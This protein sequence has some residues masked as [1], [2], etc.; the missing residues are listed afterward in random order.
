MSEFE[1]IRQMQQQGKLDQSQARLLEAALNES[2]H[3]KSGRK[4]PGSTGQALPS[5][6]KIWL[7]VGGAFLVLLLA[8]AGSVNYKPLFFLLL[9]IIFSFGCS[10]AI[11]LVLFNV[12]VWKKEAVR[13]V[14]ALILNEL[15]RKTVLVP[16][17]WEAVGSYAKTEAETL[18]TVTRSR[19]P[20]DGSQP[21]AAS[22]IDQQI[23]HIKAVAESYPDIKSNQT[24][25]RLFDELVETEN[26]I[27]AMAAWLNH[28][29]QNY[30]GT[31][32]TFPFSLVASAFDFQKAN[33]FES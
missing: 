21:E 10:A 27:T 29:V 32:E 11:F 12:L 13:R 19:N 26:R 22:S 7:W 1:Q 28:K 16:Q 31:V 14:Q 9:L 15:D 30:N 17:I 23:S 6:K 3:R 25:N 20:A 33:Y 24:Y 8:L 2:K 18:Q 4:D 5:E